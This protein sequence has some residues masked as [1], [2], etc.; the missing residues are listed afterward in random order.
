MKKLLTVTLSICLV[1]VLA[2]LPFSTARGEPAGKPSG[3]LRIGVASLLT[4]TFHPFQGPPARRIY[5]DVMYDWLVGFTS[6][7]RVDP[8]TSIAYKW[9]ETPDRLKWTFYIRDGVKFHDGSPV[10]LE[11]VKYVLEQTLHPHTTISRE[12]WLRKLEKV[13][14]VPPNKVVVYLKEPYHFMDYFVSAGH[15]M[16]CPIFPKKYIEEKGIEYFE[17]HPVGSG[18]YKFLEKKEGEYIKFEAQDRHWEVGTPKYKYITF[19]LMP[20]EGTRIAALKKGEVDAIQM[21]LARIK[22][23]EKAGFS[24]R[25]KPAAADLTLIF[26]R[27]FR[28]T[29]PLSKK[30][31]RQALVYAIDKAGINE[32]I[33]LGRGKLGGHT[34]YLFT[35]SLALAGQPPYPL[36]PY[37]PKKAKKLLAEAGYP[38]GFTIYLYSYETALPEQKLVNEAIAEYWK[39]IGMDVKIL[40]MDYGA[41][42]PIW[43]KQREPAGPAANTF[44]WPSKATGTWT[45]MSC[46]DGREGGLG[47][48]Q[49]CDPVVDENIK[50]MRASRTDEEWMK[51]ERKAGEGVM[52]GYYTSLIASIGTFFAV[53]KEIPEWDMGMESYGYCF[54]HIGASKKR[55]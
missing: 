31:V 3:E 20:E 21:S 11:D 37:D 32:H 42:R 15:E 16:G 40:E 51:Y 18:P 14:I 35:T 33:L 53:T 36:T 34:V 30:K 38:N 24:V 12:T 29:T 39:A 13:E 48:G 27:T 55:K 44:Y 28:K 5:F 22:E 9:E 50:K 25:Q 45:I 2:Q 7:M 10:T 43:R 23:V 46:E 54:D 4:E 1:F 52:A 47:F 8:T 49:M 6:D 19:K 17:K 26:Q 41:W